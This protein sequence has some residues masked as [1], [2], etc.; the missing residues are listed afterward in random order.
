M[1]LQHFGEGIVDTPS[2][3]GANGG[4]PT[5]PE[6]LDW[7][8]S[9]LVEGRETRDE[10]RDPEVESGHPASAISPKP[11]PKDQ[12]PRTKDPAAPQ[13]STLN[14]Q[15]SPWSLKHIHRLICLSATYRQSSSPRD[16]GLAADATSRL[17][18]RY[19]P[20]RLEAESIRDAILA[21]SGQL[22]RRTG[23]P[24][25]DLFE[26]NTNYVKVY[27]SKRDFTRDDFR[28]MVYQNKP[29]MQLEDTF[30]TF[31]C[32]DAGQVTPKRTS[33][34]TALQALSLLNSPFLLQQSQVFADRV[35]QATNPSHETQIQRAFELAYQRAP[36][37]TELQAATQFVEQHGLAMLCRAIYNTHEF[38][39]VR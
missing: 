30:G 18:W 39:T 24:G 21:V 31:D 14:S 20:R 6:L 32:P 5:H 27:N 38:V 10:R 17:L 28:R 37:G 25:F 4:K 26:P 9:E 1:W 11:L 23:G 33:S 22:D 36:T 12:G 19:P 35:A 29:R 34:T 2:D 8:A 15:P 16:D 7:L 13:P 3:L